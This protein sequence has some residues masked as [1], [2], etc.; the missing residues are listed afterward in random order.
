MDPS[1]LTIV[2]H[3]LPISLLPFVV[4]VLV[5][6]WLLSSYPS[7]FSPNWVLQLAGLALFIIGFML[8]VWCVGLFARIG[9]GT[10]APWDPTR[11]LV[12]R[13]PYQYV[14]NP[15]ISGVALMLV[16][17]ALFVPSLALLSWSLT[18][19]VINHLYFIFSEEP[20]MEKRFGE[21]YRSYKASVPRWLPKVHL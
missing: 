2:R 5:P 17:E 13:G 7:R 10:L 20:G 12:A 4:I 6:F 1:R 9:Q 14:R 21:S 15:M 16:G 19:M 18:F 3:L 11:N 8:F